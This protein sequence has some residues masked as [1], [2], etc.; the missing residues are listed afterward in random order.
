MI[1]TSNYNEQKRTIYKTYS[2]SGDRGREANYKGEC[3]SKLA[4][5]KSFW[6]VWHD[7]IGKISEEENN[8]YY[9][10]EY[11]REVLS[12]LDPEEVYDELNGSTLLC[13]ENNNEFCHRHI[14]AAWF[15]LLLNKKVPEINYLREE[16]ERPEYIKEYLE[17]II[18]KNINMRGFTSLRARYLFHKSELL[19]DKAYKLEEENPG[20]CYDGYRQSACFMRCSA[21]EAE[22]EYKKSI[23]TKRLL[24]KNH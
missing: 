13:Y 24:M 6:Q 7:N 20:Y 23:K 16:V 18:K 21:D 3:Y 2:I 10:E 17:E 11:W 1:Y 12:K 5:K 14:V 8:K 19:E 22:D 4:P 15:E 9:I